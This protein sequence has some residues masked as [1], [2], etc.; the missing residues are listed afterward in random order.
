MQEI[1][2]KGIIVSSSPQG[3]Y[4]KRLVIISDK[5]GKITA[6]AG[7]AAKVSSGI[8]GSARPVTC[9]SFI[10]GKGRSAYNIHGISVIDSFD[11]LG[12]DFDKSV[13]AAYV[14]EA[15]EY[16]SAEGMAE[17][18]SKK[19]LNLMFVT[20]RALRSEAPEAELIRRIYGLR[21]LVLQGEYTTAP[22]D[23]DDPEVIRLWQYCIG[24][25]LNRL[26]DKDIFGI[27]GA[28]EFCRSADRFFTKTVGH[29]FRSLSVIAQTI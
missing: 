25:P 8:T 4:G 7:G 19:L 15:G 29:R 22:A 5:L 11:D 9:A 18:D 16:F 26:Y 14:L 6:F 20:L 23:S 10:L 27:P 21:L 28:D 24:A 3:E 17:E 2:V 13:Y 1:S 12:R